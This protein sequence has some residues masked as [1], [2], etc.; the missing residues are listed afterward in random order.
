[1]ASFEDVK[2][3]VSTKVRKLSQRYSMLK[4]QLELLQK[5]SIVTSKEAGD[6]WLRNMNF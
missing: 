2:S 4:D 1:M 5:K 6:L 3:K